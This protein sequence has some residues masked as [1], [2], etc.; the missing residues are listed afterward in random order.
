MHTISGLHVMHTAARLSNFGSKLL[1]LYYSTKKV[2]K[3]FTGFTYL[4]L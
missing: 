3:L 1:A 4:G 2:L